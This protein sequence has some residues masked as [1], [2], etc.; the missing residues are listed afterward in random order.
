MIDGKTQNYM[1][2][3]GASSIFYHF[4]TFLQNYVRDLYVLCLNHKYDRGKHERERGRAVL[5]EYM[6]IYIYIYVFFL[7]LH[8][9]EKNCP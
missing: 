6:Y 8:I 5:A 2:M 1:L 9:L 7:S 4:P 3:N